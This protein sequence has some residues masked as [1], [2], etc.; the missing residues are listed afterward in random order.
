[1][2]VRLGLRLKNHISDIDTD[3][4]RDPETGLKGD[5]QQGS[6]APSDPCGEIGRREECGRL[7]RV[8]VV[9][10]SFVVALR[11]NGE[12]LLAMMQEGGF[13]DSNE[14][15]ESPDRRSARVRVLFCRESSM[16]HRNRA[17][18]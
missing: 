10:H 11:W 3:Q 2:D 7:Y 9:D 12:N 4:F 13:A 16:K 6:I 15:E 5:E 8:E 1:M 14:L 18:R 17:T